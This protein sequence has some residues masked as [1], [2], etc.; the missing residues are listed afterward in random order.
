MTRRV[1]FAVLAAFLILATFAFPELI[2]A[3]LSQIG[4]GVL[5]L[6]DALTAGLGVLVFAVAVGLTLLAAYVVTLHLDEE[7]G[8]AL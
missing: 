2:V 4:D 7:A 1:A 3:P 8:G 6:V 5:A